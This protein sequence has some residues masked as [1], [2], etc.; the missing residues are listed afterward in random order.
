MDQ[1]KVQKTAKLISAPA[2]SSHSPQVFRVDSPHLF[3]HTYIIESPSA[4]QILTQPWIVGAELAQ[5]ARKSCIDFLSIAFELSPEFQNSTFQNVA[6][7]VPLAGALY[8]NM[9]EAFAVVFGETINRCF[10]GAKRHLNTAGWITELSYENYEALSSESVILIGDTIAT[11]GTMKRILESVLSRHTDIRA[12]V[13]YSIA[14]GLNGALLI[15]EL[16]DQFNIPIY[17][18]FANAIFGVE[19]NGTD[20]PFNH[21]AT[22]MSDITKKEALNAYGSEIGRKWC[23]IWDWGDRAKYP[24]KHLAELLTRCDEELTNSQSEQTITFLKKVRQK[25]LE[26]LNKLEKPIKLL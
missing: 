17:L 1:V 18:F 23:S 8:Y 3:F 7:V 15:K 16:V 5:L 22:I 21:P 14:G 12:F 26:V 13:I 20:M 24:S 25:S 2:A 11:G 10:V 6:E 19:D 4:M 9:A